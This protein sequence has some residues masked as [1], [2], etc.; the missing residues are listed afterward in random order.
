MDDAPERVS[1]GA[2]EKGRTIMMQE[3]DMMALML[4]GWC[5]S[6]AQP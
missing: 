2:A 1:E 3:A 6:T 5:T 4:V